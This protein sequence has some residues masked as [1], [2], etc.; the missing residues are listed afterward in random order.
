MSRPQT[1]LVIADLSAFATA[2][3]QNWPDTKPGQSQTLTLI[4]KAAGYRNHQQLKAATPD[5]PPPDKLA[6][7][8]VSDALRA[9]DNAGL[10]TRWPQKTSLQRLCLMWFWARLPGRKDLTEQQVNQVLKAGET[11]GDHVLLRRSLIDH[12][13]MKRAIDGRIYRK[14]EQ[15]PTPE[16]RQFLRELSERTQAASAPS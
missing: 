4:A 5:D 9:F 2:L 8:R 3:R 12:G 1:P 13:L 15:R 7:K 11:F 16:E 6:A 14:I 10:M